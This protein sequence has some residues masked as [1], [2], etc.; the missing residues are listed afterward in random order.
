VDPRFLWGSQKFIV[1]L[2]LS[3]ARGAG[4]AK[5]WI[6]PPEDPLPHV[7]G[8]VALSCVRER[9]LRSEKM[10]L[11]AVVMFN[12]LRRTWQSR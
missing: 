7:T 11:R 9:F 4:I 10:S 8:P 1:V 2:P 5:S 3:A 12:V 6:E